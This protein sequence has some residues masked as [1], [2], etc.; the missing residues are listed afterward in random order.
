L[1]NL[2]KTYPS[3]G[4][5]TPE[6]RTYDFDVKSVALIPLGHDFHDDTHCEDLEEASD[7]SSLLAVMP[8][9]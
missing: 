8:S 2:L 9:L 4:C 3:L 6:V 7:L 1:H 5:H